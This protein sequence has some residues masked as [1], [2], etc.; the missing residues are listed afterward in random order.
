MRRANKRNRM[1]LINTCN[2]LDILNL[3]V[4]PVCAPWY[5]QLYIYV[6]KSGGIDIK[7]LLKL[8]AI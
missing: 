5:A 7:L 4:Q 6:E 8:K 1:F 2:R 3:N